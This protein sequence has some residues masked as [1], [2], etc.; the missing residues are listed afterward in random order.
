MLARWHAHRAEKCKEH[1][2]AKVTKF[3]TLDIRQ[4]IRRMIDP[5]TADQRLLVTGDSCKRRR[6]PTDHQHP[7]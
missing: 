6:P 4:A 5:T 7:K 2:G 1:T 3:A